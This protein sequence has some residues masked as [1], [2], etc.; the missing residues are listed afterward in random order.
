MCSWVELLTESKKISSIFWSDPL[1]LED[2]E[3]HEINFHR[4][5]PK[6][7]L[8]M[9][10][11]NYPSNPP[12]KWRL[13]NYNTVQVHLEFLDIQSCT[14]ENWTKTSYRLKLDINMESD[15]VS[16]S[17]ASDD[18]KIKLKSKFLYVSDITAYQNSL[19]DDQE[20]KDHKN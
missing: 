2:V 12:K 18:F 6:V 14:L 17:A 15:L 10:L 9:D 19:S 8:R 4:D 1:L 11:K 3:L 16:L 5:G 13:N 20:I 7:T